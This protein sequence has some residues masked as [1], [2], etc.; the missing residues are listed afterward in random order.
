[1][2]SSTRSIIGTRNACLL[3]S[4]A[5]PREVRN[6]ISTDSLLSAVGCSAGRLLARAI[7]ALA[8]RGGSRG[9][10]FPGVNNRE[11]RRPG[12]R[13]H[14]GSRVRRPALGLRAGLAA[15]GRQKADAG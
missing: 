9:L 5:S 12:G 1:M 8:T 14:H 7:A 13:P 10:A 4:R 15:Q 2:P 11:S 3:S 6:E